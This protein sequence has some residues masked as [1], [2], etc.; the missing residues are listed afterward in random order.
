MTTIEIADKLA[1]LQAGIG[2]LHDNY[3]RASRLDEEQH[4][5]FCN[6]LLEQIESVQIGCLRSL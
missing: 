2:L 1:A 4:C 5:A 6:L 3:A